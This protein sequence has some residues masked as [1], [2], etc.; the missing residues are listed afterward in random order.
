[1]KLL[2]SKL[3]TKIINKYGEDAQLQQTMGECGELIAV[4]HNYLRAKTYGHRTET[5][6]DVLEE[7]VDV[8]N[9][10]Q[11]IRH[12]DPLRFDEIFEQKKQKVLKKLNV[13]NP[14]R[15]MS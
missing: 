5:L 1:M 13:E 3:L 8:H 2:E 7:A 15:K 6:D 10:I 11:Q 14:K 12:M 9:M 4:I